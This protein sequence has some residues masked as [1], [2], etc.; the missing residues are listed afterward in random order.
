MNYGALTQEDIEVLERVL[1]EYRGRP[2]KFCEIGVYAGN[3]SRG[4]RDFCIGNGTQLEYWGIESG[5]LC[6]PTQPF[7]EAH[8]IV[9]ESWEVFM[10]IP[11][12]LDVAFVDGNHTFNGA[13]LDTIHYARKVKPGGF[14]LFHD[15]GDEIQHKLQEPNR[16]YPEHVW[17][18]NAVNDAHREMGWPFQGW[19][20]FE[21]KFNPLSEF[22]GM[23][24]YRKEA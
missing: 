22:G 17:F 2:L 11:D 19:K 16:N 20:L 7:S 5:T 18:H 6:T 8:F 1:A 4:V 15:T 12:D 9:G 21:K 23:T 14:I 10:H 24:A 3:T 13:V